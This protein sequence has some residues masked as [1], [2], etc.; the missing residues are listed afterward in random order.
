MCGVKLC[1]PFHEH[2]DK[3]LF[4]KFCNCCK[5]APVGQAYKMYSLGELSSN[6]GSFTCAS[7]QSDANCTSRLPVAAK[8]FS[9]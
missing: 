2:N 6:K 5:R 4:Q 7:S 8:A 9:L 1:A 3:D